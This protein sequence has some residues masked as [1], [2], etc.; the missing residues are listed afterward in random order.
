M[1]NDNK[2]GTCLAGSANKY[3]KMVWQVWLCNYN[4]LAGGAKKIEEEIAMK[5]I[6]VY[7]KS[8]A[9]SSGTKGT[10]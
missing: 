4:R 7:L 1:T 10:Q 2:T 9:E 6:V 8:P 3:K 5:N